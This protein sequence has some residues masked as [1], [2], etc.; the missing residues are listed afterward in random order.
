LTLGTQSCTGTTLTT[1]VVSCTI[2]SVTQPPGNYSVVAAF[3]GDDFY[4]SSGAGAPFTVGREPTVAGVTSQ[5]G[6]AA[7]PVTLR[8]MLFED[9]LPLVGARVTLSLGSVSCAATTGSTGVATCSVNATALGPADVGIA[10]GGD[11]DYVASSAAVAGGALVYA[12]GPGGGAFVVGDRSATGS[13]TFWGAQWSK[14]NKIS[15]GAAPDAFKG[16]A[17]NR[18][19]GCGGAW[20][21]RPGNSADPPAGALP[22][23]MAVLV[24][25]SVAKTGSA[26]AGSTLHVVVVK[27]DAG[28]KDD[29][30]HAGLGTV[31]ATVC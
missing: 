1:G 25:D 28:Y 15:R 11:A 12:W 18:G 31:V 4:V 20:S 8:G 2:A 21:T 22:G 10:F 13:V 23:F 27:T 6:V 30:G 26:I 14:L 17:A 16:F 3:A 19:T 7:G 24:T 29:P 5:G 9:G